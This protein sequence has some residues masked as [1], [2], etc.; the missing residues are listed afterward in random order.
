MTHQEPRP[1]R[2]V[3]V[4]TRL[5]IGG[6]AIQAITLSDRL[7]AR[8][9]DTVLVHGRLGEGEGDMRDVIPVAAHVASRFVPRLQRAISPLRDVRAALEIFRILR[10][11]RPAIVHTHMAK[12]GALTRLAARA[13]NW[14][15]GR[16]QGT[17]LVH[18]YHGHVLEGYFDPSSTNTFIRLERLL[19]R[20]TDV[21]IAIS[22]TIRED[23]LQR[24][25]IGRD[26]RYRVVPLGFDLATF[27][28]IGPG[29]RTPAREA[30][31]L[32]LDAPIVTTAGRLTA[33][34]Q[35]DLL[36]DVASR[37]IARRPATLFVIAGDGELR[38]ALE[39]HARGLGI[40]SQARFLGW[41]RDLPRL[42]AAA[43]LFALTSRN[44]GTP[45]ALIESMASGVPGVST[46]V[47][48]VRD[49]I[50][51][52][53]MGVRVPDRDA[54]AIAVA[55]DALLDDPDGRAVMGTRA[56]ES[57][58]ARYGIDRLVDDIE[59]LYRELLS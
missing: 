22:P 7:R 5:N 11:T 49:V 59:R 45:V 34:K 23:L 57:V 46:D 1:T 4:I 28:R 48:G 29:D 25:R 27:A 13:Y 2:V 12:A 44:E 17:R 56:R 15:V 10:S 30:L 40:E 55:I 9:F 20:A 8:G 19:A 14:T 52:A 31:G 16:G 43:D 41:Q 53:T 51:D 54:D 58:L 36:L 39:Q 18:T 32:P 3:R 37:V 26:D 6:P 50:A 38:G 21:I 33:I 47:G 35:H 42:Y 24:Y